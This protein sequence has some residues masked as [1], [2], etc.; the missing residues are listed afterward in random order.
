MPAS[1]EALPP[2][3]V[4][5]EVVAFARFH[6]RPLLLRL[7]L[8]EI[9][10]TQRC[11]TEMPWVVKSVNSLMFVLTHPLPQH[12]TLKGVRPSCAAISPPRPQST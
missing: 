12:L 10:A 8:L 1:M 3:L 7:H 4:V 5:A 9:V 2:L 11:I 6:C